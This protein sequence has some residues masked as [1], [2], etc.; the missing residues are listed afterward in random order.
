VLLRGELWKLGLRYRKYASDL[1]GNPD[2]VFRRARVVVFCDGDFWHGRDW[3]RLKRA[4]SRPHNAEHWTA[5]IAR[6]RERDCKNSKRLAEAGWLVLRLWETDILGDAKAGAVC[7][8]HVVLER[9]ARKAAQ[10]HV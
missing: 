8:Q 6:N 9:L 1:P 5:K 10:P 7:I 3:R 4:L 2:L